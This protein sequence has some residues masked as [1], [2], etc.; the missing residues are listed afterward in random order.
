MTEQPNTPE[1]TEERFEDQ[2][3]RLETIVRQLED[4]SVGL[5]GA[6]ELF[7]QGMSLAKSCRRRLEKVEQRVAELLEDGTTQELD[8]ET[9]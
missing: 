6:L 8:V 3:Q 7:E 4:E 1:A 9:S 5:E 2:L